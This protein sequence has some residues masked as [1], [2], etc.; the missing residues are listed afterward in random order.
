MWE[1]QQWGEEPGNGKYRI[2][3]QKVWKCFQSGQYI[4]TPFRH[5]PF[6]HN[7]A[8]ECCLWGHPPPSPGS[9]LWTRTIILKDIH[10]TGLRTSSSMPQTRSLFQVRTP[11]GQRWS[12]VQ[13]PYCPH[14]I[15]VGGWLARSILQQSLSAARE[16]SKPPYSRSPAC[17]QGAQL[18]Q[19]VSFQAN[20]EKVFETS[21]LPVSTM[22]TDCQLLPLG[23]VETWRFACHG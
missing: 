11:E 20:K 12:H 19:S 18:H 7:E 9:N 13:V 16:L 22:V 23:T 3:T 15:Q 21:A 10:L 8:Q 17:Q 5:A 6:Q 4:E 2:K 1:G 14:L